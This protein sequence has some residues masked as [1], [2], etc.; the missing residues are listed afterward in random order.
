[1]TDAVER[2]IRP[3]SIAIV[4]A[5][6]DTDKLTG[7][8]FAYLKK[9]GYQGRI[10]PVNPRYK[11]IGDDACYPDIASLPT[12]PDVGLVLLGSERVTEAVSE[13]SKRGTR[14]AIVLAG[15]F[16]ESGPEGRARQ[17]KLKEAAGPMRLLGP[18]TIGLVNVTDGI[19]LSASAALELEGI[20]AGKIG[21]VSQSGGILGSVLSR[22]VGRGIGFSRLIATGNESDLGVSE[23][24]DFLVDDPATDV[25]ALYLE[26]VRKP[27]AFREAAIRAARAGKPIVAFKVGRSESGIRSA[28]SHTG[29]LAGSDRAYDALFKQLGIIRA[30]SFADLLD[31]PLALSA[32]YRLRGRNLAIVTSTGGAASLVADAAGVAG[33]NTP[34]PDQATASKL[35]KLDIKDAVLDGNPIDVTLAGVK[36]ALMQSVIDTVLE[37]EMFDAV[38]VVVGSSSLHEPDIVTGPLMRAAEKSDKPILVYVSPD[39]PHI[40]QHLNRS[41]IPAYSAPESCATALTGLLRTTHRPI[42]SA[43][44]AIKA[45]TIGVELRTGPLNESESKTLFAEFGIRATDEIVASTPAEAQAA[46]RKLGGPLVVK[47]LSRDV[48]HKTEIGGVAVNIPAE[49]VARACE[50]MAKRF[51]AA[52][53]GKLDG[54]LVQEMVSGGLEF[55]LGYSRDEQL[56]AAVL[57]GLGGVMTEIFKDTAMRLVP[58]SEQDARDMIAELKSAILLHGFRGRPKADV[59]ALVGAIMAFSNMI[60]QLGEQLSEAEINPLFVLPEGAGVRAA[61]GVVVL[62][63]K[64]T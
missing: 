28:V 1:M 25:I 62:R 21:L 54:F 38:T 20:S 61:D 40:V 29:A 51:Q 49:N 59:E 3:R 33:F 42:G 64:A 2:L 8:P 4:G 6:P 48:L 46:A 5:S 11:T 17:A 12:P 39:A 57:I 23:F 55:L 36:S 58:V 32:G 30:Q 47:V 56:G 45:P 35:K 10:Y 52:G 43:S 60:E 7:R 18:N 53:K 37:S 14:A 19:M 34:A 27:E 13:L 26:G 16:G 9:H 50:D 24:I 44:S 63:A 22:A 15:G 31:L 41:G